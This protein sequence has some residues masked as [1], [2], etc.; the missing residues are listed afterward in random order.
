MHV[1]GFI[2]YICAVQKNKVI[3]RKS[4]RP[5]NTIRNSAAEAEEHETI[6]VKPKPRTARATEKG[7]EKLFA[8]GKSACIG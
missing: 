6:T 3:E 2:F 1:L 5:S 4:I 7:E 8:R